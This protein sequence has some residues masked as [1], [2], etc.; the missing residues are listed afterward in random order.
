MPEASAILAVDRN[1]RNLELLA[2]FLTKAGYKPVGASSVEDLDRILAEEAAI[3]LALVD[4]AGF[5]HEI[6]KRCDR[7]R[8]SGVPF[9][10][11]SSGQ[12]AAAQQNGLAHGAKGVLVKPLASKELLGLIQTLVEDDRG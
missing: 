2:V 11:I 12:L 9:L 10:V 4:V 6:W 5:G 1:K 3:S 8:D 7:L